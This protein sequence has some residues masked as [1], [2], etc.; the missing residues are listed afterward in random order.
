MIILS[1]LNKYYLF[2]IILIFFELYN[3]NYQF[4]LLNNNKSFKLFQTPRLTQLNKDVLLLNSYY[5]NRYNII[6]VLG[7]INLNKNIT[8]DVRIN[9][10][11]INYDIIIYDLCEKYDTDFYLKYI[12]IIIKSNR[13]KKEVYINNIPFQIQYLSLKS[14][15]YK[16]TLC[17]CSLRNNYNATLMIKQTIQIYLKL[18]VDHITIYY[19]DVTNFVL[20]ELN[21]KEFKKYIDLIYWEEREILSNMRNFGQMLKL[22]DC[23]Y[24]NLYLSE[25][26]INTDADEIIIP[27]KYKNIPKME[28]NLFKNND[29]EAIRFKSKIFMKSES[30]DKRVKHNRKDYVNLSSTSDCDLFSIHKSCVLKSAYQKYIASTKRIEGIWFHTILNSKKIKTFPPSIGYVRHTRRVTNLIRKLCK[31]KIEYDYNLTNIY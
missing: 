7:I 25:Y 29:L 11:N 10:N 8:F 12:N 30:I 24:R 21:R 6:R 23:F 4:I 31:D 13:I 18:G 15:P 5:D 9:N 16:T 27:I 3:I 28:D 17:I 2:I 22:N 19:S 14:K 1:C 20:K 26:I